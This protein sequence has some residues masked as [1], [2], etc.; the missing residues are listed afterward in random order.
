M[1]KQ[2]IVSE[3][4]LFEPLVLDHIQ[5]PNR[6]VF[7]PFQE[8]QANRDGTVSPQL[9]N[10]YLSIAREGAGVILIESAYVATQG[11][12]YSNQLGISEEK[13]IEGLYRLV[14]SI[15]AEGAVVGLRLTHAGAKTSELLAG[16][17]PV[18]PSVLNFGK[19]YN[20]SREF[21]DGDL[22]EIKLFFV[23]AAERAEEVEADFIEINGAQQFLLDQCLSLRFNSRDD[24][25]GGNIVARML[26]TVEIIKAIK[27]RTTSNIPISYQFSIYDKVEEGFVE[28]DLK[29]M[30]R[31]LTNAK[32]SIL[33]P[34]NIHV[35]NK[36][37]DTEETLAEWIGKYS[38]LPVILEGNI[39]SPQILKDSIALRKAQL[40]ALDKALFSRPNWFAF[41]Q[42]KISPA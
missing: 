32:V 10:Y 14:K 34:V 28:A 18:G 5:V 19:D 1:Q 31:V 26:L 25:Y 39:K 8:N 33:H 9:L 36:F 20:V 11:R 42:K 3:S 2:P 21:D 12:A 13:H 30:L 41:L 17:Q 37:F 27:A 38:K 35:L 16:E 24:N 22:D 40:F 15:Q 4:L 23:H 7:S 29:A 6:I